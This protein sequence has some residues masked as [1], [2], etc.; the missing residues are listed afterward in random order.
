M[1]T[2]TPVTTKRNFVKRYAAG[3]FGNHSPTW[4]TL[5]EFLESGYNS[6][7]V[8][9]RNRVAGGPTWYDVKPKE[10]NRL[11]LLIVGS[12]LD[13]VDPKT[14]YISAMAPTEKTILQGEVQRGYNGLD[15]YYTTIAKPMRD[16]LAIW[17]K[18]V[19]GIIADYLLRSYLCPNSWDWLQT[20]LERYP[21][22]VVEFSTYSANWGTLDNFNTVYWEV[23]KY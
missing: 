8:H 12:L 19:N 17:A 16:A 7:L 18:Q 11:W 15:L 21:D 9:I 2:Y 23:R 22:H 5:G 4:D 14:L 20:L 1:P 10:V 6:G 13:A 3:E